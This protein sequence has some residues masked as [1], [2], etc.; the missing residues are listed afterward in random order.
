ME[1]LKVGIHFPRVDTMRVLR[2]EKKRILPKLV[3]ATL[4]IVSVG[5]VIGGIVSGNVILIGAGAAGVFLIGGAAL[6]LKRN[7]HPYLV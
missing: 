6:N 2:I 7:K 5:V 3:M 1:N 4:A